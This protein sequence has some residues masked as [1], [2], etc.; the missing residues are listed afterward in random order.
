MADETG[1]E[2]YYW[3]A[4]NRIVCFAKGLYYFTL[5]DGKRYISGKVNKMPKTLVYI[6]E[7]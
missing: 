1:F 2:V 5:I 3:K 7:F 6:G 4:K